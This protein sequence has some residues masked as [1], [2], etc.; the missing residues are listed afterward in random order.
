MAARKWTA[1]LDSFAAEIVFFRHLARYFLKNL[2]EK[3][4]LPALKAA[5][6]KL[7]AL[8]EETLTLRKSL[9]DHLKQLTLIGEQKIKEDPERLADAYVT[10]DAL[11]STLTQDYRTEKKA[12]YNLLE[13]LMASSTHQIVH[14]QYQQ[15]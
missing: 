13:Q 6:Q 8:Q 2:F 11:I 3:S 15:R 9:A 5:I 14:R 1:E 10:F 12:L 4:H 7:V